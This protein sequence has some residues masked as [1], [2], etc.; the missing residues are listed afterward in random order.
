M[1]VPAAPVKPFAVI[2]VTARPVPLTVH[3]TGRP[4]SRPP[5]ASLTVTVKPY[6]DRSAPSPALM[7][8]SVFV[9]DVTPAV[10]FPPV[11]VAVETVA[12]P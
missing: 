6:V 11:I 7:S 2:D 12:R 5:V 8:L 3:A 4:V 10:V 1:C 9:T